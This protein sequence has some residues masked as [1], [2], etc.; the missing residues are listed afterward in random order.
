MYNFVVKIL[1]FKSHKNIR[2]KLEYRAKMLE[3]VEL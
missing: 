3:R 1:H 2:N